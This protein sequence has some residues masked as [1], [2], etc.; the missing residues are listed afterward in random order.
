MSLGIG[1]RAKERT[2][3]RWADVYDGSKCDTVAVI[4]PPTRT[5][6]HGHGN[7]GTSHE[8]PSYGIGFSPRKT[9]QKERMP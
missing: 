2:S 3:L 7:R 5:V 4:R 1:L 9:T 8:F 6:G